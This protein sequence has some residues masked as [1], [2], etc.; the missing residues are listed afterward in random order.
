[1]EKVPASVSVVTAKDIEKHNYSSVAEAL[2]QLP[3]IYLEPIGD[4]GITLRGF[5]SNNILVMVD[6][7]PVNSGWNGQVDWS[8]I[9]VH[10][11]EK[12][13]VVRGA[14]SSLY[15][16]RA[17]GGVINIT[18]K[19]ITK[20]G[21]HGEAVLSSGSNS[22]TKQV[23]NTRIK[24]D[25]WDFGVGYE[26]RKTDGWRGYFIEGYPESAYLTP[27]YK[28]DSLPKSAYGYYVI[29]GRGQKAF[30]RESYHFK[31]A[32][33]FDEDKTLTYSFF[34]TNYTY[35]YKNPFSF[36]KDKD[37]NEVFY[38]SV[39]LPNRWGVNFYPEDF[40]GYIGKK[41]W[42]VHNIAYEDTKN[43][44]HARF[45]ITDIKKDGYADTYGEERPMTSQEMSNWNGV[46]GYS[47]YPSKTKD[48]DMYKTWDIGQHKLLVGTAY[49]GESFDQTRYDLLH[50]RDTKHGKTPYEWHKGSDESWSGYLQDKWQATD[51]FAVH[52]GVR[53]D[54]YRKYNGYSAYDTGV[55]RHYAE[56]TYTEWSP[57]FA[58]E[59]AFNKGTTAFASYGHSFTPPILYQVYRDEGA[60]IENI[61][62]QL[63]V[64]RRGRLSNPDLG[65]ETTDT[66]EI[67]VKKKWGEDTSVSLSYYKSH[68][69]DAIGTYSTSKPTMMN[70]ILYQKGFSQYRNLDDS[71]TRGV[72]L[73][74]KHN[75]NHAWSTYVNYSRVESKWD[76]AT[77]NTI[78]RHLLHFGAEFNTNRW[79]ITADAQYVSARQAKDEDTGKY[80]SEDPF[81]ITNVAVNYNITPEA[82]LQFTVYNLFDRAFYANEAASGRTYNVSLQYKF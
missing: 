65:P 64:T 42:A 15:G 19:K 71:T 16:S 25:K 44:F 69:K 53:F 8:L 62:G 55:S 79:D 38:G 9:P 33:H 31:V 24:K 68:T 60:K 48:F 14:A 22:T 40:F 82:Q 35:E 73:D 39:T 47:F 51:K 56:G 46:G 23:L 32:Y 11:I 72:E 59:Y 29:G 66:Y 12:I 63:T 1:M 77:Y 58:L 10:N 17:V 30:D 70:G 26:K 41:E 43:Q 3:G 57:K 54:R 36:V 37:G 4:G 50:W 78:P 13:E 49:R 20:I 18:T 21:L 6:G 67:G 80:G 34:H 5:E 76:G 28:M 75:F 81:F 61:N 7:Q 27:N 52:A 74:L 2:G 45:G